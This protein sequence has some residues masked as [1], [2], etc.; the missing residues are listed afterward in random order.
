MEFKLPVYVLTDADFWGFYIYSVIKQGSINLSFLSDRLG[1]P[2]AKFIGL[3]TK[4]V[5]KFDIPKNVTI[6]LNQ[7]DIKRGNELLKYIWFKPQEWQEELKNMLKVGYKLELEA[8][9]SKGIKFISEKY[10]PQK[11]EEKDFLP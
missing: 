8:L 2:A 7:G 10:L 5:N 4:D 1:T 9:T 11:I 3:T 6:K